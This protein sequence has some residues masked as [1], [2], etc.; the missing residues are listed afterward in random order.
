MA[1]TTGQANRSALRSDFSGTSEAVLY[2]IE[3]EARIQGRRVTYLAE[4]DMN[5]TGRDATISDIHKRQVEGVQRV[6]EGDL[7]TGKFRDVSF[8]IAEE[9]LAR[10]SADQQEPDGDL[11]DFLEE[12]LGVQALAEYSRELAA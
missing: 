3:V 12:H 9:V 7:S 1:A 10:L 5:D 2:F 4:R 11:L 8:E 6:F